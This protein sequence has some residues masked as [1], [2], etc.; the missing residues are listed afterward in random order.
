MIEIK[1]YKTSFFR[2][3]NYQ[4]FSTLST[5][6]NKV[7]LEDSII[8]PLMLQ[9]FLAHFLYLL[10]TLGKRAAVKYNLP[11]SWQ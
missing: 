6:L 8:A 1:V 5:Q 10:K 9:W 11:Y 2:N 4:N 7:D 3:K